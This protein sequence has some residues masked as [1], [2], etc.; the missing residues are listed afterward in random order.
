MMI[1]TEWKVT[2]TRKATVRECLQQLRKSV[3]EVRA[4]NEMAKR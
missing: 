2:N 3:S 1:A 4:I